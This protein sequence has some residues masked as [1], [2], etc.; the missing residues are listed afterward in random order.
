LRV[1]ARAAPRHAWQMRIAYL[2]NPASGN[3]FYRGSGPMAA[4]AAR[5]HEVRRIPTEVDEPPVAG[6]RDVD[7]LH[8]HRYTEPWTQRLVEVA[9]AS[10]AAVVW[11]NDDDMGS[12]PK[13]TPAYRV[14]GG[15]RWQQRLREMRWIFRRADL[16]TA[17]SRALVERLRHYG[18]AHVELIENHVPD[19]FLRA[20]GGRPHDGVTIGWI[21]GLEHQLDVERLP[22][23]AV[24]QRLLD[25][26]PEVRVVT[27]GLGLGLSSER[28]RS[29]DVVAL[30]ELANETASFDVGIAPIADIDF[31]RARSNIK[32][33]EYAAAGVPWLASPTGP[34]L[35]LGEQQG[36][37]LVADDQWHEQLTRLIDKPRERRKLAKRAAKWAAGETLS[38]NAHLW[39]T[40]FTNAIERARAAAA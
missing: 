13:G 31:N 21:A 16:A 8:V 39:E 37:R 19:Q 27:F 5:G 36:G 26:R 2:A 9:K 23:R 3:G 1:V 33:K 18:A 4:L 34:Y 38:K 14:H 6:V 25:E 24:L 28:C 12:V 30:A 35:G 17:P 7:L 10:G 15:V 40:C 20:R 11:D 22:I 32:L 29:I